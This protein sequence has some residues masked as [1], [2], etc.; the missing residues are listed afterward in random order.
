MRVRI[1]P[2]NNARVYACTRYLYIEKK[3]WEDRARARI[4]ALAF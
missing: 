1:F 2:V 4:S 3:E